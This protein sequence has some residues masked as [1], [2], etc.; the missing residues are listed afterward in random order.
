MCS[1]VLTHLTSI[2][3]E[4]ST[5]W[6]TT[7]CVVSVDDRDLSSGQLSG[8]TQNGTL[9]SRIIVNSNWK[10]LIGQSPRECNT[11]YYKLGVSYNEWR[12]CCLA[13][14]GVVWHMINGP[15]KET[16]VSRLSES[17]KKRTADQENE[18]FKG[19]FSWKGYNVIIT[20][21]CSFFL[22]ETNAICNGIIIIKEMG[23]VT[24]FLYIFRPRKNC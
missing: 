14:C 17:V 22:I 18:K 24:R 13:A 1:A 20:R 10:A 6:C 23:F 9:W 4:T 12:P 11:S 16:S 21:I 5:F 2:R 3:E 8:P 19:Q 15:T 7:G